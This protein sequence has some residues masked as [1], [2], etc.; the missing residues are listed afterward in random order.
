MYTYNIILCYAIS[1]MIYHIILRARNRRTGRAGRATSWACRPAR[2]PSAAGGAGG[3]RAGSRLR[4]WNT[5]T[6]THT[7]SGTRHAPKVV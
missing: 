7:L 6:Y 2:A 1:Y 3:G 5:C 4:R